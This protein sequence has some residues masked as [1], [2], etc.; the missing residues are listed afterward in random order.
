MKVT[1]LAQ[2]VLDYMF[3]WK[4]KIKATEFLNFG[5]NNSIDPLAGTGI[6]NVVDYTAYIY[7]GTPVPPTPTI[8][9]R[10]K[11][12]WAIFT[13]QIRKKRTL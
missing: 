7:Y 5:Y 6:A 4:K 10:R 11:F 8:R 1:H 13:N 2:Q 3:I 9:K 12:P